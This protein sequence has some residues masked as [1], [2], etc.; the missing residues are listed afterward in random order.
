MEEVLRVSK[1]SSQNTDKSR[2]PNKTKKKGSKSMAGKSR[3]KSTMTS[4]SAKKTK[5]Y[6]KFRE[7]ALNGYLRHCYE[8]CIFDVFH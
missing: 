2:R 1:T 5:D 3:A 8:S 6:E 7:K 4:K